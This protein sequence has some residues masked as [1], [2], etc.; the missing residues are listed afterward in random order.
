MD[1]LTEKELAK[2]WRKSPR[3]LRQW[4]ADGTNPPFFRAGGKIL[5][6]LEIIKKIE[7]NNKVL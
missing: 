1:V 7:T 2:R 4:R 3:T 5:Y 6:S